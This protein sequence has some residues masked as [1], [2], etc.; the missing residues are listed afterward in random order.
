M[1]AKR[2]RPWERVGE[3]RKGKKKK[4]KKKRKKD[5]E[6]WKKKDD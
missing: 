5:K 3:G 4:S 1:G 6:I 2:R